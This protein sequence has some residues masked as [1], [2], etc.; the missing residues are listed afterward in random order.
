MRKLRPGVEGDLHVVTYGKTGTG[1]RLPDPRLLTSSQPAWGKWH[2]HCLKCG[3]IYLAL[4]N[5][6][7]NYLLTG[8]QKLK[9]ELRSKEMERKRKE[10]GERTEDQNV[11]HFRSFN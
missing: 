10:Q 4:T 2:R 5:S 1:A 7:G 6:G 3:V 8:D 11:L 9:V